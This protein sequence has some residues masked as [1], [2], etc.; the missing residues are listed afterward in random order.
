MRVI[1]KKIILC[2]SGWAQKSNS[3]ENLFLENF[4][5]FEVINFDYSK[6]NN[7]K[8]FFAA[9]QNLKIKPEIIA[10]WSLGGQLAC[11]LIAQKILNPKYLILIAAPFQFVKS[12]KIGAAMP[13][14]S[15]DEFRHN[16]VSNPDKTLKKFA[17]LMNINDKNGKELA[18][19]LDI[20]DENHNNL[21]FWLDE[22]EKFSCFDLDFSNFPK[23]LIFHG[24]GDLVVH[25]NQSQLF[26]EKIPVAKLELISNCGHTPH[27]SFKDY[28]RDKISLLCFNN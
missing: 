3:L 15:F 20:N 23:T 11:R 4:K 22:L 10:G 24:H 13:Q 9:I 1:M 6:F 27:I 26:L 17:V 14:K 12:S 8:D 18:D 21:A 19:N 25:P 5:E 2:L 7:L 28:L 16:F